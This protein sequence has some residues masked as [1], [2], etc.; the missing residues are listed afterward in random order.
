MREGGGKKTCIK[1]E[2]KKYADSN[3]DAVMR[4][5]YIGQNKVCLEMIAPAFGNFEGSPL[6]PTVFAV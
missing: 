6:N 5:I 4:H 2:V 1:K 3:K